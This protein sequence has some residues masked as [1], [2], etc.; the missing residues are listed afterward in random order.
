MPRSKGEPRIAAA[1]GTAGGGGKGAKEIE[2]AM[3][4][5]VREAAAEGITDPEEVRERMQAARR[6]AA[7]KS[8]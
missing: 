4:N 3:A 5:A 7:G 8:V 1:T 2:Q 6:K